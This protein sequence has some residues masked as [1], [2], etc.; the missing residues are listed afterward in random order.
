LRIVLVNLK[1]GK[2]ENIDINEN[3]SNVLL[4]DIL[5]R[6]E[7]SLKVNSKFIKISYP[8][9]FDFLSNMEKSFEDLS[10]NSGDKM[11]FSAP[12]QWDIL[13]CQ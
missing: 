8:S 11:Y 10:F 7:N 2:Q 1:T 4:R 13:N 3:K 6:L 12:D 9:K 5:D